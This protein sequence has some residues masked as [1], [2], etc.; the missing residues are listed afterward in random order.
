MSEPPKASIIVPIYKVECYLRQCIESLLAQTLFEIEIIL[1]DDGSPDRCGIICDE[2]AQRD[3]RIRV[4]HK[5]NQGLLAARISGVELAQAKYIGF[6]DGDD[7]VK[8]EM[9]EVLWKEAISCNAQV[10]CCSEILYWDNGTSKKSKGLVLK[11]RFEKE[12]LVKEFYP[13]FFYDRTRK[14]QGSVPPAVWNKLFEKDLLKNCYRNI[15]STITIGEDMIVSYNCLLQAQCVAILTNEY[16]YYY[17][18]RSNSMIQSYW[19]HYIDNMKKQIFA[20]ENISCCHEA[21]PYVKEAIER[22]TAASFVIALQ[23]EWNA[24]TKAQ[25]ARIGT[26]LA[27]LHSDPFWRKYL[28]QKEKNVFDSNFDELLYYAI[29]KK[30][31][32]LIQLC[33]A[34]Y[35]I[36]KLILHNEL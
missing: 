2:Y 32:I 29:R 35:K 11:G 21:I 36:K 5:K 10:V 13:N 12:R 34:A 17:R 8:P 6:V 26:M 19:P 15:D 1:V 28:N 24:P 7:F 33:S 23:N 31:T 25:R 9:Y 27:Q 18:Q 20:L 16:L 3:E 14:S 30:K 22:Y 4:L